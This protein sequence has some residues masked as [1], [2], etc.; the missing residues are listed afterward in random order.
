MIRSTKVKEMKISH[1]KT[2]ADRCADR[3]RP[4]EVTGESS[5]GENRKNSEQYRSVLRGFKPYSN[6][7]DA[8]VRM[9]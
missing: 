4:D 8:K 1:S 7:I 3:S 6:G 9:E 2:Y 5:T